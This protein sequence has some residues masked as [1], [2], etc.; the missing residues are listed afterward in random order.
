MITR[1]GLQWVGD[2]EKPNTTYFTTCPDERTARSR[3]EWWGGYDPAV[4]VRVCVAETTG[5]WR[6]ADTDQP[7]GILQVR[8]R[9][10]AKTLVPADV[11]LIKAR[12]AADEPRKD[13]AAAFGV[14][15]ST[16][17]HIAIGRTWTNV[18]GAA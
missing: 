8:E 15:T 6:F 1:W 3:A 11:V 9:R 7:A 14:S 17:H 13:I 10:A 18:R 2:F 16:I 12:L 4:L 5:V